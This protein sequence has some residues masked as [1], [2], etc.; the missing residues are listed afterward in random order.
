MRKVKL[1]KCY[2]YILT[3]GDCLPRGYNRRLPNAG[4]PLCQ[5]E[6]D[7]KLYFILIFTC[8]EMSIF[9]YAE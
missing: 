4:W 2:S 9:D 5:S 6:G 7:S 8:Y 3:I 1:Y